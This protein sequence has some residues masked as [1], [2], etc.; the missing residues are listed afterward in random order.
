MRE[1][2]ISRLPW[3]DDDNKSTMRAHN[4]NHPLMMTLIELVGD[5]S[6]PRNIDREHFV[7]SVICV[8]DE[9]EILQNS[10]TDKVFGAKKYFSIKIFFQKIKCF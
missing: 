6:A 4:N 10:S 3:G 5:L 1:N 9:S 7:F 8:P 2:K